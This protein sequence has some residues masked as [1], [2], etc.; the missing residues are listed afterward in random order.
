M[1]QLLSRYDLL[2]EQHKTTEEIIVDIRT[3]KC[4]TNLCV[5]VAMLT[6]QYMQHTCIK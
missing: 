3:L 1:H 2:V 5:G 4:A 6:Y